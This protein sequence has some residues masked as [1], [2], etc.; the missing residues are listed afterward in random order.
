MRSILSRTLPSFS[1][2]HAVFLTHF[3]NGL[4]WVISCIHSEVAHLDPLAMQALGKLLHS[5]LAA[6]EVKLRA[7]QSLLQLR[8][9][10]VVVLQDVVKLLYLQAFERIEDLF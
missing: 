6:S 9:F 10:L 7:L 3:R 2:S 5:R 8:V 4:I 1:I